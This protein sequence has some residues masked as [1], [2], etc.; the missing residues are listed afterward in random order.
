MYSNPTL[1][2]YLWLSL[3]LH[4]NLGNAYVNIKLSHAIMSLK[5]FLTCRVKH[6]CILIP[7]ITRILTEYSES[8]GFDVSK[9]I[10][11]RIYF[12]SCWPSNCMGSR[13]LRFNEPN[14]W[15]LSTTLKIVQ[16][17]TSCV[18]V[19]TYSCRILNGIVWWS[20][21]IMFCYRW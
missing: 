5:Y 13:Q 19:V 15:K 1:C 14:E 17:Q 6:V 4:I 2:T 10:F 8:T 12:S 11:S 20:R 18:T 9:C 3:L 16:Q 21:Y 7:L